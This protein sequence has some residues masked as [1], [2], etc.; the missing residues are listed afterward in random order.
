MS[1]GFPALF[2]KIS[3]VVYLILMGDVLLAATTAPVWLLFFLTPLGQSW[4]ALAIVSPLLAP[5]VSGAFATFDAFVVDGST[6][7]VRSF[8]RGWAA[9][10]RKALPLGAAGALLGVVVGVD[11]H[12][13]AGQAWAGLAVPAFAVAAALGLVAI[14]TGLAVIGARPATGRAEALKLGLLLGVRGGAWSLVSLAALAVFAAMLWQRPA[15]ALIAAPAPVL[16]V[17]W[18]DARR[19]IAPWLGQKGEEVAAI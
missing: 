4:L 15:L 10:A 16:F 5:A 12:V 2:L 11:L 6:A 7:V 3:G 1:S 14:V 19:A 9:S 8:V 17:V 18:Y 13:A